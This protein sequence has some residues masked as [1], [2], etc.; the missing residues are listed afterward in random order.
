MTVD[1]NGPLCHCG[2]RGC[3]E[4]FAGGWAIAR[5]S[6][7]SVKADPASGSTILKLAGGKVED[8]TA[9]TVA[10]GFFDGDTLAVEIIKERL[11]TL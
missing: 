3:M 6:Q 5:R 4:A 7:E 11:R 2:N 10:Q 9:K 8:I 1:L